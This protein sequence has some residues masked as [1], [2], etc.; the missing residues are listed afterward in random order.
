M[1]FWHAVAAHPSSCHYDVRRRSFPCVMAGNTLLRPLVNFVNRRPIDASATE[2][3]AVA[4][5]P[6]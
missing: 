1:P 6:R 5:R 3:P 4:V 2:A